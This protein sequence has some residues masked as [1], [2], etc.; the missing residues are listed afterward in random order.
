MEE[1]V[2]HHPN[3]L[4][5]FVITNSGTYMSDILCLLM[6]TESPLSYLCKEIFNENQI[7]PLDLICSCY[8]IQG[9]NLKEQIKQHHEETMK[10]TQKVGH[11]T[12]RLTGYRKQVNGMILCVLPTKFQCRGLEVPST[13]L[14]SNSQT[15]PRCPTIQLNSDSMASDSTS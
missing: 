15:P 1:L 5:N 3:Q 11:S 2:C 10:E 12:A 8:E 13:H 9:N 7:K 4:F 6:C 14:K